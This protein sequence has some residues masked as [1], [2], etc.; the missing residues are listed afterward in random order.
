MTM[1]ATGTVAKDTGK[2]LARTLSAGRMVTLARVPDGYV[3]KALGDLARTV[4]GRTVFVAR[5]G[6]R[7]AEIERALAFFAPEVEPL[8]FPAW[9]C[10][11]YD[12]VSPHPTVVARRMATLSRLLLPTDRPGVVLTTVNAVL[13]RAPSRSF[14][15]KGSFSAAPGNQVRMDDLVHWLEDNGF[16]AH[17]HRAR[18]RRVRRARR[19]PRPLSGRAG[20]AGPARLLRRHAGIDPQLRC[21]QPA[22]HRR[23]GSAS[24]SSPPNEMVLSAEAISA[25][26]PGL[27]RRSSAPPI[28]TIS[29]TSRSARAAAMSAW[30]TGC[31]CSPTGW[32]RSSTTCRTCRWSLDHLVEEAVGERLDLIERSLRGAARRRSDS[33]R[34][35]ASPYKPLPPDRLY[36]TAPNGRDGS[37]SGRVA[38]RL[39][40]CPARGAR[41]VIDMGGAAGRSFAAE[42]AA[43]DVNVFDAVDRPYR[44]AGEGRASAS[45][46]PAGARARATAWARC[47]ST[48]G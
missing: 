32:R 39:A 26:S 3:G 43:G 25:L 40:L 35:A 27:R 9:D 5:D 20:G 8:P 42:R 45:C 12:R 4:K 15:E 6:Q 14:V 30:S 38:P 1:A 37:A 41:S 21:R 13:Q 17:D 18:G 28:A 2:S 47:W 24:I 46:S 11:P 29:S 16:A 34:R 36:L 33:G 23:R 7:L 10:L 31:R 19:H 44:R 22:H 48:T